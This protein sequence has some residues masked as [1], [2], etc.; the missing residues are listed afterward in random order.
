MADNVSSPLIA[1]L[2]YSSKLIKVYRCVILIFSP[3]QLTNTMALIL[4]E[5]MAM[6]FP[7]TTNTGDLPKLTYEPK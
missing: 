6:W 2:P 5:T 1:V 7:K 3:V 4:E